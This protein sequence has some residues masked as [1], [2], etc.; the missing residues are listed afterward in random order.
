MEKEHILTLQRTDR[1]RPALSFWFLSILYSIVLM[2]CTSRNAVI[3]GVL[4]N[5]SYDNE[6]VYW[7]PYQGA[8][9]ET[10]D[11]ARVSKNA[12]RITISDYNLNKM[13]FVRLRPLLRLEMQEII[14]Y[15]EVGTTFLRLDSISSASGTPLNVVLQSWKDRKHQYDRDVSAF[16]RQ[17][18]DEDVIDKEDINKAIENAFK[19]YCN[20]VFK[21]VAVN[22]N[23]DAGKF[24]YSLH[25]QFFTTE[26]I[27]ELGL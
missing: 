21:V 3:E 26:Q 18:R 12:F 11:S 6:W 19:D 14:V 20:D 2:S 16:Y 15:T 5:D 4:P 25:K 1:Y 8:T 23:N 22:K 13:G 9:S 17:L 27:N 7:V 10:V 24:I